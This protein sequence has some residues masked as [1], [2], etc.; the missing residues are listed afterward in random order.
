M[1]EVFHLINDLDKILAEFGGTPSKS[2]KVTAKRIRDA[3]KPYGF[4]F[5]CKWDYFGDEVQD[6]WLE[7][8]AL[9]RFKDLAFIER[10]V[11][12]MATVS[13]VQIVIQENGMRQPY[14]FSRGKL[15]PTKEM[16]L[17]MAAKSAIIKS[18]LDQSPEDL[19]L[20]IGIHP[21]LDNAI[22]RKLRAA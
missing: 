8:H 16:Y 20:F 11:K 22:D 2:Q 12:F 19:A 18:I 10:M 9:I 5:R 17:T 4:R 6:C 15:K 21:Y 14:H 3:M 13:S 7:R 1:A